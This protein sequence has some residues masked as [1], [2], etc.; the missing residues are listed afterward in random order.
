[1][2]CGQHAV[3]EHIARARSHQVLAE[4]LLGKDRRVLP[5]SGLQAR[6]QLCKLRPEPR[7]PNPRLLAYMSPGHLTGVSAAVSNSLSFAIDVVLVTESLDYPVE[8]V[9]DPLP[10]ERVRVD[11]A[12]GG[13][14]PQRGIFDG[15]P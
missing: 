8:P 9:V 4:H 1:V 14:D 2:L 15:S 6:I 7:L 10:L 11:F 12:L 3:A 5:G 13:T